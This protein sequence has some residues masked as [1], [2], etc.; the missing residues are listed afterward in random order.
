MQIVSIS[1]TAHPRDFSLYR[2]RPLWECR[3]SSGK[4]NQSRIICGDLY[5]GSAHAC[6]TCPEPVKNAAGRARPMGGYR[7]RP[8]MVVKPSMMRCDLHAPAQIGNGGHGRIYGEKDC[9]IPEEVGRY[10]PKID[11]KVCCPYVFILM[12]NEYPRKD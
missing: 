2:G 11:A 8:R 3:L 1:K 10:N 6:T 5:T 7:S 4:L 9:G 12:R